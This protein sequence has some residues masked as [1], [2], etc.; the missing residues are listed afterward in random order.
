MHAQWQSLNTLSDT[1]YQALVDPHGFDGY[2]NDEVI[3]NPDYYDRFE[4]CSQLAFGILEE[5]EN[6]LRQ[7]YSVCPNNSVCTQIARDI[8]SVMA[9]RHNVENLVRFVRATRSDAEC[10]FLESDIGRVAITVYNFHRERG[11]DLRQNPQFVKQILN[12]SSTPC[13]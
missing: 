4:N 2:L 6:Q 8:T 12:L 9:L 5:M 3:L 7:R 13:Q 1:Y 11:L 10:R